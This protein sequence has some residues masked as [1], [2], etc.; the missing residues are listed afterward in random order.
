MSDTTSPTSSWY[1][2][3]RGDGIAGLVIAAVG[4]FFGIAA[5]NI[6][7]SPFANT[8]LEPSDLPL[9]V[10]A[11]LVLAGLGLTGQTVVRARR[12]EVDSA[13]PPD[14][15]PP[16]GSEPDEAS[17]EESSLDDAYST[18]SSETNWRDLIAYAVLLIGYVFV[19]VPLGYVASTFAFI[20]IG[21]LYY[22]RHHP[23][24]NVTYA[25]VFSLGVFSLFN[26]AL[27]VIL[28]PGIMGFLP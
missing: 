14:E 11:G 16:I 7:S 5:L 18:P 23:V 6:E 3:L 19:L 28:P 21:T 22:D 17:S 8:V 20:L 15:S 9:V 12:A 27:D 25:V 13:A 26:Y 24:R 10:A 2:T 4:V 1:E